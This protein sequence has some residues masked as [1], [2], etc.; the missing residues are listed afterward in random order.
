VKVILTFIIAAIFVYVGA[1]MLPAIG[2]ATKTVA[3]NQEVGSGVQGL[4]SVLPSVM[5]ICFAATI[6][7]GLV[8]MMSNNG[9][10]KSKSITVR[11]VRN[12]KDFVVSIKEA[13]NGLSQYINNLDE[14]LN[15]KTIEDYKFAT[16]Y[17]LNMIGNNLLICGGD[18]IW[19]WY[20][21]E[22]H[23]DMDVFKVVGLHK[24]DASKNVLYL[25]GKNSET[26]APFLYKLPEQYID[27]E[28][29][30][31]CVKETGIEKEMVAV[32]VNIENKEQ[33]SKSYIED[34]KP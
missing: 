10:E 15:I 7:F 23:P 31:E 33:R 18:T 29:I 1:N 3:E 13:S 12:A 30:K 19:D 2:E 25:L 6:I 5:I 20:I 17:G 8:K 11:L 27:K 22:K 26:N 28:C 21:T 24:R 9:K 32:P 16:E 4:A 34:S 14:L